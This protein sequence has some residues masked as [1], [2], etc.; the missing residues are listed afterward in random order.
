MI[1][2]KDF[3]LE[4]GNIVVKHP[5]TGESISSESINSAD[6]ASVSKDIHNSLKDMDSS[7]KKVHGKNLFG[8]SLNTGSAYAGSTGPFMNAAI[9]HKEFQK[10]KPTVGDID[11]QIPAEHKDKLEQHLTPGSTFGNTKKSGTK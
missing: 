5:E 8:N 6:R 3:L 4:G 9:P 10:H 11:V 1:S 2:F 7:F